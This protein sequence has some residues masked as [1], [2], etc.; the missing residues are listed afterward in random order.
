MP[1]WSGPV[2]ADFDRRWISVRET[3]PRA[4]T[5]GNSWGLRGERVGHVQ[6]AA[7]GC[8]AQVRVS[9]R[10]DGGLDR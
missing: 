1:S 10:E 2:H 7:F 4:A 8:V 9:A 5:V 3:T 6:A